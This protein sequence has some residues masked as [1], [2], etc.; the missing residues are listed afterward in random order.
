MCCL[1]SPFRA[2]GRVYNH[3]LLKEGSL[4]QH[5]IEAIMLQWKEMQDQGTER[6]PWLWSLSLLCRS[7]LMS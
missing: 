1:S 2:R 7:T 4:H 3:L 6:L 5:C